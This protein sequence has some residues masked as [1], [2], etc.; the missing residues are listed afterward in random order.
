MQGNVEV[1]IP[2]P[3]SCCYVAEETSRDLY[4][5]VRLVVDKTRKTNCRKYKTKD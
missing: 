2:L 4:G 1:T 5:S 3:L